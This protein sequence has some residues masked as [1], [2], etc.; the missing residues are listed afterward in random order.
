MKGPDSQY[1]RPTKHQ[2]SG[3]QATNQFAPAVSASGAGKK[4]RNNKQP[5]KKK[6]TN[7]TGVRLSEYLV[8]VNSKE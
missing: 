8:F 2:P 7:I 1:L 3:V 4:E 6:E 5:M